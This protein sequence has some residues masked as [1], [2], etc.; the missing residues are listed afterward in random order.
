MIEDTDARAIINGERMNYWL[1]VG[2][3]PS[4]RVR[5]LIKKYGPTGT[6]VKQQ[7]VAL[8]KLKAPKAIPEPGEPKFVL[9]AEEG[10]GAGSRG[11]ASSG[12]GGKACGGGAGRGSAA[13]RSAEAAS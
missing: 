3:K 11:G 4:D 12:R 10:A 1:G 13:G 7:E 9:Q 2:A 6:H 5:V 8:A